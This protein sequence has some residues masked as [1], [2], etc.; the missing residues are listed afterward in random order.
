[1]DAPQNPE[2]NSGR[3]P[4]STPAVELWNRRRFTK[5]ASMAGLGLATHGLI[6]KT[7]ASAAPS[8]ISASKRP[9]RVGIL[10]SF[11]GVMAIVEKS[12]V[13]AEMLAVDEINQAGGVLG[14]RIE[15]ILEDG[16]SDWSI[17]KERANKLIRQDRVA[18]IF[19]C[20]TS[21]SRKACLPI[22]EQ[23]N[24]LLWYPATYEGQECSKNIFYAGSVPNQQIEPSVEW[25]LKNQGKDFFLLGSDYVYPRTVNFIIKEKLKTLNGRV[26]GEDYLPLGNTELQA[27]I[28]KIRQAMPQGGIIY[29][30]L[31][32]DSNIA[33]FKQL[34]GAGMSAAMYPCLSINMDENDIWAIAPESKGHYVAQSYFQTVN[35]V[36]NQRFVRA[37]KAKYGSDRRLS[38]DMASAYS[39]VHLWKQ[40]V[41]KA[42]NAY[43][44]DKVRKAT[45]KQSFDAP[46]GRVTVD[47]SQ[48]LWKP[49]RIGQ[50]RSD[51][52]LNIVFEIKTPIKPLPWHPA[53][54]YTKGRVCNW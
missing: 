29:N 15:A 42:G 46:E 24:H 26:L 4:N 43:Q 48:H 51:G 11:S 2:P 40:A 21:A 49:L 44:L 27:V 30:S 7:L 50:V 3:S 38:A 45:R 17:F 8:G 12:I 25:L 23:F 16:A 20:Y 1:M 10:H 13:D 54:P 35:T 47:S 31:A 14:Q 18:A 19:G 36:A 9:I 33:F 6:G 5:L 53:I 52:L 34:Q 41:E 22:F 37:F 28:D 39:M 32:G